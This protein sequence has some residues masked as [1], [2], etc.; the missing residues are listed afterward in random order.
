L[1][2]YVDILGGYVDIL[3]GYVD[4]APSILLIITDSYKALNLP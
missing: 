4:I 2:G 3:G 1:G